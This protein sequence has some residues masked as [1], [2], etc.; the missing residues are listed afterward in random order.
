ML[1]Y[2]TI[3]S[4]APFFPRGARVQPGER[5]GRLSLSVLCVRTTRGHPHVA[6]RV[7]GL[8]HRM[9]RTHGRRAIVAL[10]LAVLLAIA[11]NMT[12]APAARAQGDPPQPTCTPGNGA[13]YS[14]QN[15][16]NF[17]FNDAAPGS[18]R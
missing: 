13:N 15:L 3:G 11:A 1:P 8:K 9:D 2:T 4:C 6:D 16:T 18:L 7:S 17:P 5:L 14:G 12:A 10:A